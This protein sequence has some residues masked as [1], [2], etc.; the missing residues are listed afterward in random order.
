[1]LLG[2]VVLILNFANAQSD[3]INY[4]IDSK[5]SILVPA[6]PTQADEYSVTAMTKDSLVCV[7]TRVDMEKVAQLDS[8][9]LADLAPTDN[10]V[11]GTKNGMLEKMK[12]FTLGE[13]K[14]GKWNGYYSYSID[15]ANATTGLRSYT[16][17]LIIGKILYSF[18]A[19][20]PENKST[21][22]KDDFFTSLKLN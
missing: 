1:L 21:Q 2:F 16:L 9:T 15:G 19:V 14:A 11:N 13:L 4:K 20:L 7:I 3:W 22:P 10:F 8:T 5:L 17:M 18:S 6:Q 12:G